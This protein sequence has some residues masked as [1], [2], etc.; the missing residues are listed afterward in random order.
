MSTP[1]VTPS[2][3]RGVLVDGLGT[4]CLY[5]KEAKQLRQGPAPHPLGDTLYCVPLNH[6]IRTHLADE[7][8]TQACVTQHACANL[9]GYRTHP[10]HPA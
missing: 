6:S 1:A 8:Q 2:I 4:H 5:Q 7:Q 9:L 10:V 3:P